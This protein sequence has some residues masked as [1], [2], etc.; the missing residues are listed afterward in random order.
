MTDSLA[1]SVW[2]ALLRI[3][4]LRRRMPRG[5]PADAAEGPALDLT[6]EEFI[7]WRSERMNEICGGPPVL[8]EE[9]LKP[10]R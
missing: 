10:R 3:L 5:R 1:Q 4:G 7:Q 2:T 8:T 6:D 9:Q